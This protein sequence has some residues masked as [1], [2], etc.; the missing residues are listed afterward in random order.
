MLDRVASL[1]EENQPGEDQDSLGGSGAVSLAMLLTFHEIRSSPDQIQHDFSDENGEISVVN[2]V[3][4][5]RNNGLKAKSVFSGI[6]K[7]QSAPLP[8]LAAT[9]EGNWFV[10]AKV[11]DDNVLVQGPGKPPQTLTIDELNEQWSGT[12]VLGA[13]RAGQMVADLQFG[14]RWFVP[15]LIKYRKLFGEVLLA[16]FFIQCFALITP[17]FFQVVVDKVLVHRGVTTLDVLII[18]LAAITVFETLLG[19]LRTYIFSHTTSRVDV[20]LGAQ[21]YRHLLGLPISY[22]ESRPT[23]QTVARVHELQTI[24][25][26]I[27]SSSLTVVIDLV[28]TFVFFAVMWVFS[29][30]LTLIVLASVPIYALLSIAITP[31]LRRRVEE[32]FQRGATNQSF[33]VETISGAET[34]KSMAV[35]PQMHNRWDEN[36]AAY[37]K[38]SF[39]T[40]TLGAFGSQFVQMVNKLVM[41]LILW[42]GAKAVMAGELTVGQLVAFNML[43]GQVNQPIIR[44]AQLWQDFQQFRI[45]IQRLG[46]ILNTKTELSNS[47]P[48]NLPPLKGRIEL[49]NVT[50]RYRPDEAEILKNLSL[51]IEAGQTIGLV[52]RSGSG[53][54]TIT[55][56]VQRLHAPESGRVL[57]DGIEIGM[58]NPAWLRRQI[59]IV[60]QENILFNRTVRDNIALANPAMSMQAVIQA[61]QLAGA[62]EF[63]LQLP[64]GYDTQLE[65]RG[66]NLSG[67]Q[68][69][70][71]AIA[72]ALVTNPQILILDEATAALDYESERIFQ[73]NL[74]QISKGRTVL[75]IAHRLSTV[76]NADRILVMDRGELVEDGTHSVLMAKNGL[77]AELHKIAEAD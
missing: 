63:I 50:F 2:M 13:R 60:L 29:P 77:Y 69:Q 31:E 25:D 34:L 64:K 39:R 26:F 24:R 55:K 35:E 27:T 45:S 72:R 42:V 54:S 37:V 5:A 74:Q 19:F 76:R 4:A 33:L 59:G 12:L 67:G 71:I 1:K 40:V 18:G 57:L 41:G 38:A 47:A 52:G 6:N 65:E 62:H 22:F 56:L 44:L 61:A 30:Q 9:P 14:M 8:A 53:K 49:H 73:R 20:Q 23:G 16:S 21:L 7:L 48:E 51:K 11:V 36:L 32:K 43:A 17:L 15:V 75:I 70:R 46:D 3:R 28:F 10:L 68:R 66:S 58:L